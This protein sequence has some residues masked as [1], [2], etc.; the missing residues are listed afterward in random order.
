MSVLTLM[1]FAEREVMYCTQHST[2][3]PIHIKPIT[4]IEEDGISAFDVLA[5]L[6]QETV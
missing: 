3:H 4:Q 2:E 6:V 1:S 5:L